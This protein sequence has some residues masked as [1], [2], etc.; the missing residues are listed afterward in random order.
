[1]GAAAMDHDGNLAVGYSIGNGT[2]PNYPSIAYAGRLR[3]DPANE[4]SQGEATLFAG[5]GS[6]Q[7]TFNRWGDYSDMTVDP[8]DD[9]TFW[10]TQEYYG[11]TSVS[12]WQTRVGRFKFPDCA[13]HTLTV[14]HAGTGSGTITSNPAGVNCGSASTFVAGSA[15]SVSLSAAAAPG[16]TFAGFSG[17]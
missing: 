8:A 7:S 13:V 14:T 6:Q 16:S 2:A 9:C 3:D 10:Y 15:T 17:D 5:A 4:L 1:M 11:A 12:S